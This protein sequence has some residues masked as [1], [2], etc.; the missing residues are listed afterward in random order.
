MK[1]NGEEM[2][3]EDITKATGAIEMTGTRMLTHDERLHEHTD[4]R[5]ANDI[6][7]NQAHPP[8]NQRENLIRQL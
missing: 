1:A 7:D 5:L 4:L 6:D 8:N 2:V 3:I